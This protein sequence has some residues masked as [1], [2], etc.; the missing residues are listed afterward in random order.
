MLPI[1]Y[2]LHFTSNTTHVVMPPKSEKETQTI[3][4]FISAC[5]F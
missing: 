5:W 4:N 2:L 1:S 3:Q